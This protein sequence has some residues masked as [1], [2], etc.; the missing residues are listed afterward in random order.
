M[1]DSNLTIGATF[2]KAQLDAAIAEG[3]AA[4]AKLPDTFNLS[5]NEM[6]AVS[7]RALKQISD[8]TKAATANI[9][10]QWRATAAAAAAYTSA[11][12]E[13]RAASRL[14]ADGTIDQTAALNLL[15][16]AKQKAAAASVALGLAEKEAAASATEDA[17][18][19][20]LAAAADARMQ[21]G[22]AY[23][24]ARIAS[25]AGGVGSLGYAIGGVAGRMESIAPLL[26]DA[27]L[28][29]APIAF[30]D[31]VYNIANG[32]KQWYDNEVLLKQF[33][34][35]L[36]KSSEQAASAAASKNWEY[37]QSLIEVR[38]ALGDDAGAVKILQD[39]I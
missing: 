34:D 10:E 8:D 6:S 27:F 30:A 4:I 23:G 22:M 14:V 32:I 33:N 28:V 2:D 5:F 15:A 38:R 31:V 26:A 18:A 3:Q 13:V 37:I 11:Q 25:Y 12:Q 9:S 19:S 16:A 39:N 20:T 24:A 35:D 7:K 17:G 36:M 21:Y 1:S 29:A